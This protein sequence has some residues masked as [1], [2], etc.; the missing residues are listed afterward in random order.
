MFSFVNTSMII[1]SHIS[2]HNH[3]QFPSLYFFSF[4]SLPKLED[5][6]YRFK[7]TLL[8]FDDKW[9]KQ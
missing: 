8:N 6:F 7:N 3:K 2:I 5:T 1:L 4:I 9:K